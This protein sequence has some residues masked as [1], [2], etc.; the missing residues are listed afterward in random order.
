MI[1]RFGLTAQC[2][3]QTG[4]L[5]PVRWIQRRVLLQHLQQQRLYLSSFLL[6]LTLMGFARDEHGLIDS[7]GGR[8]CIGCI[9]IRVAMTFAIH[10]LGNR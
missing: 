9:A 2:E 10:R 4:R 6:L 3:T 7:L 5:R 8:R 1:M